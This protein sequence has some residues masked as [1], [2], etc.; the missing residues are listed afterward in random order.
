V[1]V[2]ETLVAY[3]F[4]TRLRALAA[5]A[6]VDPLAWQ[7]DL[8][9][10]RTERD[11]G[12]LS[13]AESFKLSLSACGVDPSPELV[14]DLTRA[15]RYLM[16]VNSRPYDDAVPFL[17]QLR[18]NGIKVALVSN[19]A[20]NTRTLLTDLNLAPLADHVIL[21]CEIGFA[22]PSPEIYAYAL[23]TLGTPPE[24]AAM[25]DDLE[26]YCRGAESAGVKAIQIT[27]NG[28]SAESGFPVARSLLDVIAQMLR[29]A[30]T[31]SA[32]RAT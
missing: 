17:R 10:F 18:S 6:G 26:E 4:R 15:D 27:R 31:R 19:C 21:S 14:S 16:A 1:D 28:Q 32:S 2:Y 13:T 3:D 22:K 20:D 5:L 24:D 9:R 29:L 11:R 25:V 8:L 30:A 23:R 12:L 7:H